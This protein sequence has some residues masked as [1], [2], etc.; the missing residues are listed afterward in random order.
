MQNREA[1]GYWDAR[2]KEGFH[3][4]SVRQIAEKRL[5]TARQVTGLLLSELSEDQP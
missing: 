3:F 2:L 5:E 1:Y 4:E